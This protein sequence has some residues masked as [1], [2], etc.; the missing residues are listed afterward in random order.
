M[1][2]KNFYKFIIFGFVGGIAGLIDWGVFNL[3]AVILGKDFVM[4]QISRLLGIATSM[5]WNFSVNR[6]FTFKAKHEKIKVQLPKWLVLYAAT[7]LINFVIFSGVISLIGTNFWERNIAFL[8][9][10]AISIPLNFIGSMF[11]IFRKKD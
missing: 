11:W 2:Q 5:I 6:N 4:L 1:M 9:G 10:W 8:C 7:S 3:M